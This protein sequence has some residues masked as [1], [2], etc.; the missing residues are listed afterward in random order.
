MLLGNVGGE[1][2]FLMNAHTDFL[3]EKHRVAF[4]PACVISDLCAVD[5]RH[6]RARPQLKRGEEEN[7]AEWKGCSITLKSS[8]LSFR[9]ISREHNFNH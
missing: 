2:R 3:L 7:R 5:E 6:S 4:V 9:S 1:T 8:D